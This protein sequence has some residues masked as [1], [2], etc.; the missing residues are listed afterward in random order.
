MDD[1]GAVASAVLKSLEN[2][3]ECNESAFN[4]DVSKLF[5][6]DDEP[7]KRKKMRLSLRKSAEDRFRKRVTAEEL[8]ESA[9]GVV[10]IN[11]RNFTE[12]ALRNFRPWRENRNKSVLEDHVPED[13]FRNTDA[14]VLCKWLCCF[15]QET[16]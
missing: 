8:S 9:K 1:A 7:P 4:M 13:L 11:T 3:P 6:V 5:D 16:R 12:W 2:L 10:P 14:E 15:V